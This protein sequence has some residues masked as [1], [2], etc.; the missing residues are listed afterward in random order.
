MSRKQILHL[1]QVNSGSMYWIKDQH[2]LSLV[3]W[4]H[5]SAHLNV[6]L[7]ILMPK[8]GDISFGVQDKGNIF[9]YPGAR[10]ISMTKKYLKNSDL[11]MPLCNLN[12]KFLGFVFFLLLF[13]VFFVCLVGFFVVFFAHFF[14]VSSLFFGTAIVYQAC[15]IQ[16][17]QD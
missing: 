6:I 8:R 12:L 14:G 5:S 16:E 1:L 15:D 2:N 10:S 13:V 4:I 17:F 11:H 3:S 9:Y 7:D